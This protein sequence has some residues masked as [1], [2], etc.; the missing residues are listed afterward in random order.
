MLGYGNNVMFQKFHFELQPSFPPFPF[1][2]IFQHQVVLKNFKL[3]PAGW[4]VPSLILTWSNLKECWR[5]LRSG[6]H[7]PKL[8]QIQ[9]LGVTRGRGAG[10]PAGQH[11]SFL[12]PSDNALPTQHPCVLTLKMCNRNRN[13]QNEL[14][15][16][17]IG[18]GIWCI[19]IFC[20]HSHFSDYKFD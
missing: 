8:G 20:C 19:W 1:D 13:K 7:F 17:K 16:E 11:T 18:I 4:W 10:P 5:R 14:G 12:G 15:L 6:G 2:F 9:T 3:C